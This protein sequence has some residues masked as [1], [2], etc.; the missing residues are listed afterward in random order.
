MITKVGHAFF[1][2]KLASPLNTRHFKFWVLQQYAIF[3]F[4]S[5]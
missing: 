3:V 2:W 4:G 5:Y 1:S